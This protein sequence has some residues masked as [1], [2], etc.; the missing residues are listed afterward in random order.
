MARWVANKRVLLYHYLL[1]TYSNYLLKVD[2]EAS[3]PNLY[4]SLS[5]AHSEWNQSHCIEWR[6]YHNYVIHSYL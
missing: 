4:L 3:Y 5:T 6:L 2:C 1:H